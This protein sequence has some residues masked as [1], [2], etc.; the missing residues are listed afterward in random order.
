MKK[1]LIVLVSVLALAAP[2]A[3]AQGTTNNG[4]NVGGTTGNT[5]SGTPN[6]INTNY[7]GANKSGTS[8]INNGKGVK[9]KLSGLLHHKNKRVL[10]HHANRRVLKR[11]GSSKRAAKMGS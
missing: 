5:G 2:A 1:Q 9:G 10:K 7:N 6:G 8:A 11:K 4:T 3:L